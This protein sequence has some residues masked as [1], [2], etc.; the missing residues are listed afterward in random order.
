[1][2]PRW[3]PRRARWPRRST[4]SRL[5][6]SISRRTSASPSSEKPDGG[7]MPQYLIMVNAPTPGNWME[8]PPEELA[9]HERY[10]AQVEELGA[11]TVYSL[12]LQP[13]TTATTIR[14]D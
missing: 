3:V 11:S 2:R 12:A 10:G 7:E 14:G 4:T 9:A 5:S 8:A 13:S 6:A 1:M